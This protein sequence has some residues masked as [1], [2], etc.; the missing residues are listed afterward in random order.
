MV[1]Q[2]FFVKYLS[3]RNCKIHTVY[4]CYVLPRILCLPV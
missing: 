3:D 1:H 4:C 2:F